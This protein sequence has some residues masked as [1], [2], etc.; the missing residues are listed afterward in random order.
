MVITRSSLLVHP[1]SVV[2]SHPSACYLQFLYLI[3]HLTFRVSADQTF[4][5]R[6]LPLI[7]H[8]LVRTFNHPEVIFVSP[9]L[10]LGF[11]LMQWY[12]FLWYTYLFTLL[13]LR[14]LLISLL[15]LSLSP[16]QTPILPHL[17]PSV[18]KPSHTIIRWRSGAEPFPLLLQAKFCSD[19][20]DWGM[21][22]SEKGCL[23]PSS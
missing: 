5:P 22:S 1:P 23:I 7:S 14:S 19:R 15:F 4:P 21:C 16:S 18:L 11:L 3:S 10:L 2:P 17:S 6:F 12:D 20:Q 8:S 9:T 13:I